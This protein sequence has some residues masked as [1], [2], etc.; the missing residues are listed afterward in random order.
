VLRSMSLRRQGLGQQRRSRTGPGIDPYR[1][2]A[3]RHLYRD[4]YDSVY[5]IA[6]DPNLDAVD[7]LVE[8]LGTDAMIASTTTHR[9]RLRRDFAARM[10]LRREK[11]I[12]V[13][14]R[15]RGSYGED[16]EDPPEPDGLELPIE[17]HPSGGSR[18]ESLADA[19]AV[20][21][22]PISTGAQGGAQ[23]A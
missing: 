9:F 10:K 20:E 16:D 18:R 1:K 23:D 6:R 17:E 12:C 13:C 4:K 2:R 14:L 5:L 11:S 15:R 8:S 22:P 21:H 19:E 3:K 7:A